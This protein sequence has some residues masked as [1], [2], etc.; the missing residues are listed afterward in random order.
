MP[1]EIG[2]PVLCLGHISCANALLER[3]A[4]FRNMSSAFLV[5]ACHINSASSGSIIRAI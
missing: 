5:L 4:F 2:Q 1:F 3:T